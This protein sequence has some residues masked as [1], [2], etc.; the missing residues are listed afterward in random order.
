[1]SFIDLPN[2]DN[3][4]ADYLATI[5]KIQQRNQDEKT[6]HMEQE[7]GYRE[8]FKPMIQATQNQTKDLTANLQKFENDLKLEKN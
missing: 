1:M 8:M 2:S 5:K 4:V 3:V 6:S 7:A